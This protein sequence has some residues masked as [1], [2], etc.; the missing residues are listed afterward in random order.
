MT[1]PGKALPR[2]GAALALVTVGL[3]L[4]LRASILLGPHLHA[5]FHAGPRAYLLLIILPVLVAAVAR[6]PAG[7]LTDRYGARVMFP[8]VSLLGAVSVIALGLAESLPAVVVAG[9][10]AGASSSAFVVGAAFVARL[11]PYGRRG[12]LLG[13]YGLGVALAVALS[14]VSWF[15]DREGRVAAIVLGG[16]L[17]AFA[18]AA[19]AMG[20]PGGEETRGEEARGEEAREGDEAAAVAAAMGRARGVKFGDADRSGSAL[21]ECAALVRLA[22]TSSV[23][24]LYVVAL[25]G[26]VS[27]GLFLPVYLVSAQHL[28]WF[29][30]LV[31]TGSLV[32][33]AAVARLAGGWCTDRRPTARLLVFCY[34]GAAALCV[35]VGLAP[36]WWPVIAGIA[37][38]DGVAGGALL[39][40][41]GKAARPYNVGAVL[42]VTG[43][44]GALGA[45]FPALLLAGLFR[46]TGSFLTAWTLLGAVLLAAGLY[47]H[48]RGLYVGLGLPVGFRPD[49]SPTA[50]TV[51]VLAEP[52]TR[53]G[54]AAVVAGLAELATSDEVVIVYG[55]G[56]GPGLTPEGLAAGLRARLPRHSVVAIRVT[57]HPELLGK[58]AL[59]LTEHMEAGA[60]AIA[61]TPVASLADVAG[62]LAIYLQ[63]DRVLTVSYD[64]A[65]GTALHPA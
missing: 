17:M 40:L 7:V 47:V 3:G 54:A 49:P 19:A 62:D 20:R 14:A 44:A 48:T 12:R 1:F 58:D 11:A 46:V 59:L 16:L 38:C 30:A 57:D 13:V 50:T 27:I 61:V 21:R 34:G 55:A 9:T 31:V 52:D 35:A 32:M 22:A 36:Q 26:M 8:A 6:L 24:L 23:T 45:I 43:A 33:T 29:D 60:L 37:V 63:A 15:L 5:R 64:L 56:D 4:N 51:A 2:T 42:G 25:S 65:E 41:I 10:A 18:A 53:V 28:S 39:A